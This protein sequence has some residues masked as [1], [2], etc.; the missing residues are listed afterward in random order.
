VYGARSMPDQL[1]QFDRPLA[2][3][4]VSN[5]S[6]STSVDAVALTFASFGA[7]LKR[8]L[9]LLDSHDGES[10]YCFIHYF[11]R[12]SAHAAVRAAQQQLHLDGRQLRLRWARDDPADERAPLGALECVDMA[13]HFLGFNGW[14][15][16][17]VA[18]KREGSAWSAT[19]ALVVRS[20]GVRVEGAAANVTSDES[21]QSD[22]MNAAMKRAIADARV[23]AFRS[24]L[25]CTLDGK[26]AHIAVT[27]GAAEARQPG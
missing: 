3:V 22:A 5:I 18:I 26:C 11:L 10:R 14:A 24:L 4:V 21:D 2:P 15:T 13:N 12:E 9:R 6:P 17:L 19:V 1:V 16:E 20:F 27:P 7:F 8:R 23:Q 25:L